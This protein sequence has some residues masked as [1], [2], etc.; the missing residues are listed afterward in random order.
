[1]ICKSSEGTTGA[2]SRNETDY[3]PNSVNLIAV[4]IPAIAGVRI[5][6]HE[7]D[8][9]T[10]EADPRIKLAAALTRRRR[11]YGSSRPRER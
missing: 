3:R 10:I 9:W 1:V 7:R 6:T 4:E 2:P 8:P 11:D 5:E